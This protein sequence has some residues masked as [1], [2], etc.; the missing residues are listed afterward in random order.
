MKIDGFIERALEIERVEIALLD[1]TL[2]AQTLTSHFLGGFSTGIAALGLCK[3]PPIYPQTVM[4]L[5]T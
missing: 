1:M 3:T 2:G 4:T 5:K